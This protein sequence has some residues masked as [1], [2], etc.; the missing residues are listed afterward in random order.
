MGTK[1]VY[2]HHRENSDAVQ[3][4]TEE[5]DHI[6]RCD[7]ENEECGGQ[8]NGDEIGEERDIRER[9]AHR[10]AR[11]VLPANQQEHG[12]GVQGGD[13]ERDRGK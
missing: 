3:V 10:A 4:T 9:L 11:T 1:R 8:G 13:G 6:L 5:S 7:R 12:D 2:E